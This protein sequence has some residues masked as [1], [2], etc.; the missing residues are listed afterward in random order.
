MGRLA[1]ALSVAVVAA[2]LFADA[3]GITRFY[4]SPDGDDVW[5]GTAP[6]HGAGAVGP[7]RT[8]ARARGAVRTLKAEGGQL[9]KPVEVL[10]RGGTYRLGEPIVF[11][12]EDSGSEACP[13]TYGAYNDETPVISGGRSVTG[14]TARE[15]G[16][17]T[18]SLPDVKS[19]EWTF[20]QLFVR[21]AGAG[22]FTR[23]YRPAK[24]ALVVAGLT[25]A[26]A[27]E[28]MSHR[29][30]QDEFRFAPGD[31]EAWANIADVEVVALHDWS[32][33]RLRIREIDAKNNIV[34]FTGFPVY[35]IGHWW[36]DARNPYYVENVRELF[37]KPG[38]WYLDRPTGELAYTPVD[39]ETVATSEVVAPVST[40]LLELKGDLD[41]GT[42]VAHLRFVGLTFSHTHWE[43]P[44]AGYSSGQGMV[45]LPAAVEVT[46]GTDI[47]FR[48]CTFAHL[49][50]YA[51]ALGGGCTGNR[52]TGCR[53]FDL[54]GGGVKVGGKGPVPKD[55]HIENNVISDG[56][57]DHFSAHGIWS[58]I[59]DGTVMRHNLVR[60]FLY[61]NVSIGWSWND[62]PTACRANIVEYNHIHD[63]MMLLADGGAIY[64]LGFQPGT[65]IRGN[66]IHDVHRSV[67][68]GRAP[69]NGMFLDQGSKEFLIED[70]TIYRTNGKPFRHNQNSPKW[71]TWKGNVLSVVPVDARFPA[72][73]V[74]TAGP[75]SEY[76]QLVDGTPVI[77]LP[78]MLSME[79]PGALPPLPIRD[80]FEESSG[81]DGM[82]RRHIQAAGAGISAEPTDTVAAQGKRSFRL[83]DGPGAKKA[84]YPYIHYTPGLRDGR[85][86]VSFWLHVDAAAHITIEGRDGPDGSGYRT[87]PMLTVSG[88]RITGPDGKRVA[89]MPSG[90]WRMFEL[91]FGLGD[92]AD[93]RYEIAVSAAD[94]ARTRATLP[95]VS[96]GF[97]RLD[98]FGVVGAGTRPA[99]FYLDD[100][101][102]LNAT[103][104]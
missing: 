34:R 104:P 5:S 32:S 62:K 50:A 14:W 98:W 37:G 10:L 46:G 91:G 11:G 54:G 16:A 72:E 20:R 4:V 89:D 59:T 25:N 52:V 102:I 93:G 97:R 84:F 75:E 26:P 33:S 96:R 69:N 80:D 31:M 60:R 92:A 100:V 56:G 45:D 28:G 87:G 22:H 79:L 83:V 7:F 63:A 8:V 78:P 61:S 67:F 13:I 42:R 76:R 51:L 18:A 88:G 82:G 48:G 23:R 24:G 17:W 95:M 53:M 47:E 2:A 64:S 86:T 1:R 9:D 40:K 35:R 57:R 44:G 19:G 85:A 74:A 65:V 39:G 71:H 15:D 6:E 29:R 77:P 21:Q 103:T 66:H 70:N 49:G 38:E 73:R 101:K 41:A 36:R 3:Q 90:Q 68:A 81:A 27:R 99:T 30:S 55:N 58:G 43:L 94:G 12:A